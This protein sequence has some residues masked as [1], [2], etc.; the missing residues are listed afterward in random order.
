MLN[1]LV[2]ITN[3]TCSHIISIRNVR[4]IFNQYWLAGNCMANYC[5]MLQLLNIVQFTLSSDSW[6]RCIC[7]FRKEITTL[8][9]FWWRSLFKVLFTDGKEKKYQLYFFPPLEISVEL[10]TFLH[11]TKIHFGVMFSH[12]SKKKKKKL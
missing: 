7:P 2:L 1:N 9:S 10:P 3:H 5:L 6:S 12:N 8:F 4:P 11:V